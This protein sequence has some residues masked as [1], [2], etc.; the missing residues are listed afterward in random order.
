MQR[1]ALVWLSMLLTGTAQLA[2]AD[3]VDAQI[4]AIAAVG[5]QGKGSAEARQACHELAGLGPQILPRLLSAMDT[6]NIVAAN[7]YRAAYERIVAREL[8]RS[9]PTFPLDAFKTCV[10]DPRRQGRLRRLAL[11][12]L[13]QIEPSFKP[14]LLPTLL[15]DPEF[16]DDAV[17]V[18]LKR[19][20]VLQARG[21]GPAAKVAYERAFQHARNA[22]QVTAAAAK[23][24][25]LGEKVSIAAHLGFVTEWSLIGPFAASGMTGF[26]TPFSP[27]TSVD[28]AG[29]VATSDKEVLRWTHHQTSDPFGTVD[30]V[31]VLGP[32][33][34]A[35]GYAYTEIESPQN[36]EAQIRSSADDCLAVWLNGQKVFGRE[37]WLNG[38]R[39]DRFVT[40]VK[41]KAGR[42]RLLVK[43][44]Q[45]PHHRDPGVGNAWTFQ[46]R[47]C[48]P[49]GEGL[50]LKSA[51]AAAK[52]SIT[53]RS[54]SSA[55]E[56]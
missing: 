36:R 2:R 14:A 8:A 24:E 30:L 44:C 6:P 22:E 32:V 12:L 29:A 35:V 48:S 42:N 37:M 23:L 16:R 15:D 45:G 55:P 9:S 26:R 43:V 13:D 51:S 53:T 39:F 38:T 18:A 41:L 10:R 1:V 3:G 19:A 49:D 40:P 7:W 20:D 21:E 47:F 11:D 52:Q 25:A 17:A 33:N 27:E 56:K 50:E 31:R 46:L 54:D 4:G 34:E 28:L 5:S